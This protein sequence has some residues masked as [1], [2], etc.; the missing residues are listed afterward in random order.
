MSDPFENHA[1]GLSSPARSAFEITPN[2][3]ADLD[4]VTRALWVGTEGDVVV[5]MQSGD[6]VTFSTVSGLL[7]IAV[8]RVK[9][10]NTTA[11]DIVGLF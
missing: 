8:S 11:S 4:N 1:T 5:I 10:T 9:S 6:E 7:P 2:D 3:S